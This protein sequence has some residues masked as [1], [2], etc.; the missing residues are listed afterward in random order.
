MV[1]PDI[2]LELVFVESILELNKNVEFCLRRI[3]ITFLIILA[4]MHTGRSEKKY[5]F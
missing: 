1:D 5:L 2:F 4:C 3:L